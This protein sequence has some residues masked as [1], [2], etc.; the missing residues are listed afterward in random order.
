MAGAESKLKD[1]NKKTKDALNMKITT[2][3]SKLT[4]R[5]NDQIEGL[6]LSS[7][8]ARDEMKKELLYAIRTMADQAKKNLDAATDDAKKKFA[9]VNAAEAAAAKKSAAGRAEIADAI[10]VEAANAAQ[11]LSD[12]V[13]TMQRSLLSLKYQTEAKIKKTNK[14]VDAY[15]TALK[16]EAADVNALMKA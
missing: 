1:M 8:E 3:I 13:A 16:K 7:K 5:A 12:G 4:K 10:K 15:A 2:E 6:K 14:K 9:A 11:E